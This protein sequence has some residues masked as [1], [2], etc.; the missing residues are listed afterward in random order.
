MVDTSN[1][2]RVF[3]PLPKKILFRFF[4]IYFLLYVSPWSWVGILPGVNYLLGFYY[5]VVEALTTKANFY[6]FQVF[7]IK[8]VHPV[9]NGSGD[10][11]YSWAQNYLFLS[12][13]AIGCIIWT[14][15]DR[16]RKGYRQLNY[17][18]CLLIRYNLV[19]IAFVYGF[20]KILYMQMPFP[21]LSQLA[22]PLGDLLPMRF[23]WLFIG[24]STS[25]QIF[26]G[27]M[28]VVAGSLLLWRRTAT[29]G[30]LVA[31]AVFV[32]VMML[33]LCYDIPVKLFS[34]NLVLMCL[35]LLANEYERIACFFVLNRPA[36]VCTVYHP[37]LTKKWMRVTRIVLK[38]L[39]LFIILRGFYDNWKYFKEN[40]MQ[41]EIPP[42]KSGVYDVIRFAV[43]RATLAPLITDTL[44]WQDL[45][46]EPG[47]MGSV[48]TSDTLFR[49]RYGRGYF[50]YKPDSIKHT[51]EFKKFPEDS[52]PIFSMNFLMPDSNT[53]R[54]WGK[55]QNDSLYVELKKSNRHFQLAE[56][57]FHWLSEANR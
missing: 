29:M 30:V 2:G 10:T 17:L 38:L 13:A 39:V 1:A 9:S 28:E 3:W 47:G 42:I 52:I 50:F 41:A 19:L 45:I 44:R 51:L 49:R 56:R 8:N 33:N 54:L 22:T 57:Q 18:L 48:K 20:N 34:M 36:P 4:F 23:S 35:Y 12:I 15:L 16:K 6:F 21:L 14:I 11:S 26:S 40:K 31:T 7:N 37:P 27:V 5:N 46:F 24:Y 25:Y 55:K 32:N 53:V 43:N